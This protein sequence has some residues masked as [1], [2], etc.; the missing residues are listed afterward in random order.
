MD[1]NNEFNENE[2]HGSRCMMK[3]EESG[4]RS[5]QVSGFQLVCSADSLLG[6]Q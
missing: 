1:T 4:E 3:I 2:R 6:H 5:L